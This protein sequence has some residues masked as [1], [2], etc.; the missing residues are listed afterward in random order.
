MNEFKLIADDAKMMKII[1]RCKDLLIENKFFTLN[2]IGR[3]N[4]TL[5]ANFIYD[6]HMDYLEVDEYILLIEELFEVGISH[7][8]AEKLDCVGGVCNWLYQKIM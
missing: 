8:E 7:D 2:N 5:E 1:E 3:D 4:V 6:Y